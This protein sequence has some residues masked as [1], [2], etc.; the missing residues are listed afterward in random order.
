MKHMYV[1]IYIGIYETSTYVSVWDPLVAR[2]SITD[3]YVSVH[4]QLNI[5]ICSLYVY[6]DIH[7]YT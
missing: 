2:D 5:D 7:G 4:L 6:T 1:G 3:V